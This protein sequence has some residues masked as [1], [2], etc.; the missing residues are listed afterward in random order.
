MV[1]VGVCCLTFEVPPFVVLLG[2]VRRER[3]ID[4]VVVIEHVTSAQRAHRHIGTHPWLF[5]EGFSGAFEC[6]FCG[7]SV[8]RHRVLL[9]RRCPTCP[10]VSN[11]AL[12][13]YPVLY[14]DLRSLALLAPPP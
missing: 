11:Q 6:A 2:P 3:E 7:V 1:L 13:H 10:T 5:S 12:I 4:G 9:R 8:G 14:D